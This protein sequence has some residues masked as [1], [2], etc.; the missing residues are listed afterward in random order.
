[1]NGFLKFMNLQTTKGRIRFSSLLGFLLLVSV[2]I[3][4]FWFKGAVKP[5]YDFSV[6]PDQYP[7]VKETQS[8][9]L[10]N[11]DKYEIVAQRLQA[12]IGNAQVKMLGYNGT[13]PGP[14]IYVHQGDEII[15]EFKNLT[16][17]PSTIH[18]HG[19]RVDNRYD[20]VPEVTQ[21]VVPDGK[22]FTYKIKFD[23]PGV[24]WYHPHYRD[25]YAQ[26]LGLY[27]NYIVIPKDP[28]YWAPVN[29]E[30]PLILTDILIKDGKLPEYY[31]DYSNFVFMGR[32]GNTFLINGRVQPTIEVQKGE[33]IRFYLTNTSSVRPFR[34]FVPGVKMKLVG[35]DNGR[36]EKEQFVDAVVIAPSERQIVEMYFPSPGDFKLTHHA[37]DPL[38]GP[39]TYELATFHV[40]DQAAS[41]SYEKEFQQLRENK[42]LIDEI[43]P[44]VAK[45]KAA[46]PD[47]TIRLSVAVSKKE[48]S[49]FSEPGSSTPTQ[50]TAFPGLITMLAK[51]GAKVEWEDH[52][53]LQNKMSTS[54]EITW[55]ITDLG[56]MK[57]NGAI[58]DWN[59]KQGSYIKIRII[60]D[61]H[62]LHPMQHPM[63]FHG[64]RFLVLAVNDVEETNHVWKDTFMVGAG[65]V[66]D[67]LLELSNPGKW[68]SHCHIL[69]HLHSGMMFMYTVD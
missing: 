41:V 55:Q 60:N 32:Y 21:P 44:L 53:Y 58:M 37:V 25:D 1:M 54:K 28:H 47:R 15:L 66:V 45:Y 7:M 65:D 20:G 24:Y 5:K 46:R 4:L 16:G 26:E 63:H 64:N 19:I 2:A 34:V 59:Y 31:Q 35:G 12:K 27:G 56:T 13:V 23:D 30:I 36:I 52:M 9:Y 22:S 68:M 57:T 62:S 50:S 39:R 49:R 11:G 43:E 69:E 18:H 10:K 17:L 3:F 8:V 6:D 33:V 42:E 38:V 51:T 61:I 29:R 40:G 67:V 48:A 14:F